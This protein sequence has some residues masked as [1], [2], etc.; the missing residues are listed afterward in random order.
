M[1]WSDEP[2]AGAAV[3]E[4]MSGI[5]ELWDLGATTPQYEVWTYSD[6]GTIFLD[7]LNAAS[8]PSSHA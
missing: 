1:L 3:L 8:E 4:Q 5:G 7:D 6:A 2:N